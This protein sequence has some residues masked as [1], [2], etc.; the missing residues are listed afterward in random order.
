MFRVAALFFFAS[1]PLWAGSLSGTV[2]D[3]AGNPIER[4]YV[5]V[6]DPVGL[7][8]MAY[9]APDITGTYHVPDLPDGDYYVA[10]DGDTVLTRFVGNQNGFTLAD[11]RLITIAGDRVLNITPKRGGT[12]TTRVY[13]TDTSENDVLVRLVDPVTLQ[14]VR[15]ASSSNSLAARLTNGEATLSGV[16]PG[17]YLIGLSYKSSP[18]NHGA[19]VYFYPGTTDPAN[20]DRI[21]ITEGANVSGF[22]IFFNAKI[23]GTLTLT[24]ND[25]AEPLPT[26]AGVLGTVTLI[27]RGGRTFQFRPQTSQTTHYLPKGEYRLGSFSTGAFHNLVHPEPIW[28]FPGTNTPVTLNIH[29]GNK[30]RGLVT[31][32]PGVFEGEL[33][34]VARDAETR[35]WVGT[36]L[37][38]VTFEEPAPYEIK[39]L[40]DGQYVLEALPMPPTNDGYAATYFGGTSAG[41]ATV[42]SLQ[43]NQ[44]REG[45]DLLLAPGGEIRGSVRLE[46]GTIPR[47]NKIAAIN[48][49]N[50]EQFFGSLDSSDGTY[51]IDGLHEGLFD[52]AIDPEIPATVG[53]GELLFWTLNFG[54]LNAGVTYYADAETP[55]AATPVAL[56][57][58]AL[59]TDIDL[60]P[61]AG[62]WLSGDLK[63]ADCSAA[64]QNEVVAVFDGERLLKVVFALGGTFFIGG[65]PS[66]SY[67][68][69]S[70]NYTTLVDFETDP[71][72]LANAHF[73]TMLE[74]YGDTYP[75]QVTVEAGAGQSIGAWCLNRTLQ[76]NRIETDAATSKLLYAWI[77]N[78]ASFESLLLA[79]NPGQTEAVVTLTATRGEGETA[80][81]TRTIPARGFMRASAADL[82]PDLA[83]GYSVVLRSEQRHLRGSWVTYNRQSGSGSGQSP[84]LANAIDLNA[85]DNAALGQEVAFGFLPSSEGFLSA[86]VLVNVGLDPS[87]V[88]LTLFDTAGNA[89]G[90]RVLHAVQ[91]Y[92]PIAQIASDLLTVPQDAVMIATAHNG[93]LTGVNFV[94]NEARESAMANVTRVDRGR[95]G[96]QTLLYPWVSHN[97]GAFESVIVAANTGTTAVRVVLTARREGGVSQAVTRTIPAG[98]F[99]REAAGSLFTE[100]GSGPGYSVT[101]EAPTGGLI[102]SWVTANTAV[103]QSPSQGVAVDPARAGGRASGRLLYGFLPNSNG[104]IAAP[105]FL[106]TGETAVDLTLRFFDA[107]GNEVA[108]GTV[109]RGTH[110]WEPTARTLTEL[111]GAGQGDVSLVVEAADGRLL[112]GVVFVF[113][114]AGEPAIANASTADPVP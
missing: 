86:P 24:Y 27:E 95:T 82:F 4:V 17:D 47:I 73:L 46:N 54:C 6:F 69:K 7:C 32:P 20:A 22:D 66:G 84:S 40:R 64:T 33:I 106:H 43:G 48:R 65:L 36:D 90:S 52:I 28:V 83:S 11:A 19:P 89:I 85:T 5:K 23:L 45:V 99:L 21:R 58:G 41:T 74:R 80:T 34:M 114:E 107:A 10:Y 103:G 100:L 44:T 12:L 39:G 62:G 110:P 92:V 71:N 91:P 111:V 53:L 94:F 2:T 57:A 101:L 3:A 59:R 75:E 1:F 8:T 31:L 30:L 68:L 67:T 108:P 55:A 96:P 18:F 38:E 79:N 109:L 81:A 104:F 15:P 9:V 49:D 16:D 37:I 87:D 61:R 70:L 72:S 35:A 112:T 98:G 13:L 26:G 113:N 102:G 60:H 97:V 56:A 29:P 14:A 42:L 93:R 77:S 63:S 78:N 25:D 76:G 50:G 51:R 105:V 88:T